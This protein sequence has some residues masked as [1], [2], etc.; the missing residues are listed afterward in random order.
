MFDRISGGVNVL[1]EHYILVIMLLALAALTV[2]GVGSP[3]AVGMTGLILCAAGLLQGDAKVD[4]W[5]LGPL[6]GYLLL[7]GI[8]C[9]I[10]YGN[11]VKSYTATQSILLVLY[12]LMACLDGREL[13]LF[14]RFS[15]LWAG[16]VAAHG[17]I[18][19]LCKAMDGSAGRLRGLLGSPNALG[20][21]FVV[22]WFGLTAWMPGKDEKGPL[23]TLLRRLEPLILTALALTLSMGSFVALAAGM[24]LMA[25]DW[26]RREGWKAALFRGCRML[27]KAGLSMGLGVLMYF[28]A[29]RTEIPW[30]CLVLLVYLLAL[31]VLW[32]RLDCFL[33]DLPWAAVGMTAF[34][35]L[36]AVATVL[37]RPSSIATFTERL[38]MMRNGLRYIFVN[39]LLG[40]GPYQWRLLNLEDADT[41]FNTWHIHNVPIHVAVELG[42]PALAAL[43]AIVIRVYRKKGPNR[44]GFTAFLI[45]NLMDTGFF[46]LGTMPLVLT[47][48]GEPGKG[49]KRLNAAAVKLLF[50]VLG[51][52]FAYC[53]YFA[54]ML[55]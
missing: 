52:H 44:A 19:F 55:T 39:P 17:I 6:A 47:T 41:Y 37:I 48:T 14:R 22:A 27:A 24:A 54:Q 18:Q 50:A 53:V 29:R 11:F 34:G 42:L 31:T 38:E 20:I 15:I 10:R 1:L 43:I 3:E 9:Y 49:G 2:G 46:Y 33:R 45:H 23:P 51:V 5:I 32:E 4:L 13:L 36:V 35:A 21:F 25:A 26:P 12:L 7:G 40:V 30:F 16:Y 28:T 8:S